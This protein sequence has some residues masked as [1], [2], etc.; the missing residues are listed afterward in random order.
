MHPLWCSICILLHVQ[1]LTLSLQ[2]KVDPQNPTLLEVVSYDGTAY[3]FFHIY[4]TL[5]SLLADHSRPTNSC[6]LRGIVS[7]MEQLMY[8]SMHPTLNSAFADQGRPP[9]PTLLEVI[10][11]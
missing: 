4:P 2:T 3:V 11:K 7:H 5:I 6:S 1:L 10:V 8:S 9:N